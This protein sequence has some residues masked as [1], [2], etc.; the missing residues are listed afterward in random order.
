MTLVKV[1]ASDGRPVLL[2]DGAGV[3]NIGTANIPGLSGSVFGLPVIVDPA[4]AS[5]TVYMANSAAVQ[6][7]ESAGSPVRLTSGDITTLTDDI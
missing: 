6:T 7:L 4:L 1:A 2:Q 5:G 3:N